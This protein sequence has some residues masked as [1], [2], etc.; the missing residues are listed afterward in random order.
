M[1]SELSA[2][3]YSQFGKKL[4]GGGLP[5]AERQLLSELSIAKTTHIMKNVTEG[6]LSP[7]QVLYKPIS[8]ISMK[9]L[10]GIMLPH[11]ELHRRYYR[12][13]PLRLLPRHGNLEG[14]VASAE[15]LHL[16]QH[17]LGTK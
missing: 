12:G 6:L 8:R 15:E 9:T 4:S 14:V 3:K 16:S 2:T 1:A 11:L 5:L 7:R 17:R 10:V 13:R